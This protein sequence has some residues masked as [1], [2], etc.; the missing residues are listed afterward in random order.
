MNAI[1][2]SITHIF[3]CYI[4]ANSAAGPCP[5]R[6][7]SVLN[8]RRE[9]YLREGLRGGM[10]RYEGEEHRTYVRPVESTSL[11]MRWTPLNHDIGV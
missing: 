2:S 3:S 4:L 1:V 7:R 11:E 5:E 10:G 9:L 6:G 8:P